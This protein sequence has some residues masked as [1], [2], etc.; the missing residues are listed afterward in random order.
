MKVTSCK[1]L[2]VHIFDIM[3]FHCLL[4]NLINCTW[5]GFVLCKWCDDDNSQHA[6]V[7]I[8]HSCQL[9]SNTEI[10]K[11]VENWKDFPFVCISLTHDEY[12]V[13]IAISH[14]YT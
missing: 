4:Q 7:Y 9:C 13:S 3:L 8:S 6:T 12:T 10:N 5:S 2:T 11:N 1:S 14:F